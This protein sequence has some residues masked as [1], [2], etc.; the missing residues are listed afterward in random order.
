MV[1]KAKE[2]TLVPKQH[3]CVRTVVSE[4][5]PPR[6]FTSG[7]PVIISFKVSCLNFCLVST[8]EAA[9]MFWT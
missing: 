1:M 9:V 6:I 8:G 5:L 2:W 4:H 3:K 7:A